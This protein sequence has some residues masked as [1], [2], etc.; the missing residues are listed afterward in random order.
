[1]ALEERDISQ[2]E[3]IYSDLAG[4]LSHVRLAID[5][6]KAADLPTIWLHWDTIDSVILPKLIDWSM[7]AYTESLSE[8]AARRS[9]L[10][11]RAKFESEKYRKYGAGKQPTASLAKTKSPTKGSVVKNAAKPKPAKS[12]KPKRSS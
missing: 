12:S 10:E 6:I 5:G 8:V 1:M 4:C 2:L 9:G 11:P 3:R 7:K